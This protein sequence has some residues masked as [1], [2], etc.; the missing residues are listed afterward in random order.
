ML[1]WNG[2]RAWWLNHGLGFFS[3][4]YLGSLVRVPTSLN[5]IRYVEFL[6]NHLHSFMLFCYPHGNGVFLQYNCLSHKSRLANGWFDEHSSDFSII[7]W[8]P[9]SPDLPY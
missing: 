8:P 2:T 6:G 3:W 5:A 9:R 1:G 7:N 4:L